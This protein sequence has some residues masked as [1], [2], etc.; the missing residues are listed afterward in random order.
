MNS[1][2]K[3]F[4]KFLPVVIDVE[5]AGLNPTTDALLEVGCVFIQME[6]DQL[7]PGKTVHHHIKPFEG[8]NL[9]KASLEFNNIDPF[10]P[11]RFAISEFEALQ[12]LFQQIAEEVD[13]TNCQRSVLVGHNAWFDLAFIN[14]ASKRTKLK[15][16]MHAFTSFDTATLGAAKYGHTVLA[17]LLLE[18]K[19]P[20]EPNK[21]HGAL[22]DAEVTADL[23]CKIINEIKSPR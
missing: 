21:A 22:Y 14:A 16:P 7:V 11:F 17:Q 4:R 15:S 10:H 20:Y 8:A 9:D 3:R 18:A 13:T 23:F 6:N 1:I 2:S 19:I 12:D 5:T